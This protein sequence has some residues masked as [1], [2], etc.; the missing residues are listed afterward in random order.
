MSLPTAVASG[1][2][3]GSGDAFVPV[4]PL[5]V[6]IGAGL[7]AALYL[8]VVYLAHTVPARFIRLAGGE[9]T[10]MA[11]TGGV[12]IVWEPPAGF[13]LDKIGDKLEHRGTRV[14]R[15]GNRAVIDLPN[16]SAD[17]ANAV[18]LA[19]TQ[20]P[21]QFHVVI[22]APE[23]QSLVRLFG[24]PGKGQHPV[25]FDILQWRPDGSRGTYTDYVLVGDT[26][27][28]LEQ[29]FA[30]A[31]ARGWTLPPGEH[32][33]YARHGKGW[34]SYV[35][36]DEVSLDGDDV[37][38]A[39]GSIDPGTNRPV[40]SLELTRA[41]AEK[42]G[43][44]T[45]RIT[46]HKLAIMTGD[47]VK[48]AP[49]IN[50]AIH[51]G[52]AQITMGSDEYDKQEHERDVLVKVLRAGVLPVGGTVI[53]QQLVPSVDGP[54]RLWLGRMLLAL[55]GGGL[56]GLLAWIVVR[57][58]RPVRR[59]APARAA[60]PWPASRVVITLAVPFAVLALSYVPLP[61]FDR[62]SFYEV[63]HIP[64]RE[65]INLGSLGLTPLISAYLFAN[66]VRWIRRKPQING[67]VLAVLAI[68][69]TSL[70][71][72]LLTSYLESISF[73]DLIP[74]TA[75]ARLA[76]L[77]A[78][79]AATAFL[80]GLA[81]IVRAFGLG[82]GYGA[83][84]AGGWLIAVTRAF[85]AT[86]QLL[87]IAELLAIAIPV[88]VVLRWRVY[89]AGEPALRVPSSSMVPVSPGGG[90]ALVLAVLLWAHIGDLSTR[91][92]GMLEITRVHVTLA[93]AVIVVVVVVWSAAFAWPRTLHV[94][95]AS[96]RRATVLSFA[97]V[98]ACG[99][100]G[101]TGG[102][103]IEPFV[104]ALTAAVLLDAYDDL[105]ARRVLLERV[106]CVHSAH[107][108]EQVERRLRDANIPSHLSG[109]HLR[110]LT[111]GFG[112]FAPVDVLVPTEHAP[113]ARTLL[114]SD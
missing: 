83:L 29:T 21:L 68:L 20:E 66:L 75:M 27:A 69:F 19:L 23:M 53:S 100:V 104:I 8:I 60:G 52:R 31:R 40:V 74:K 7:L 28:D 24:L 103:R 77:V 67:H 9:G 99:A 78:F 85:V 17:D 33:A 86:P 6:A 39:V 1:V 95:W 43:E 30:T 18:V 15:D 90:L 3:P 87:A 113:A 93:L 105:R 38:N 80:A 22:E 2:E 110:T 26:R 42:F 55:G 70:Q 114:S 35:V 57:L 89:G 72:W 71:A 61:L 94:S 92:L 16:V 97:I 64:A 73:A 112:G 111:G 58:T 5:R 50:D 13:D 101:I 44:V 47:L 49:I 108:A 76:V 91:M 36:A 4:S 51:G 25:D 11:R 32:V 79:G 84:I 12:R 82:N 48:S 106:W 63:M 102:S 96:W 10:E 98:L 37:S 54:V 65:W 56:V 88:M 14:T 34:Q 81:W 59:R 41:G 46:G 107:L 45:S 62:E 109:S